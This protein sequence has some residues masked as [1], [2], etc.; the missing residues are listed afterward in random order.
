MSSKREMLE[1]EFEGFSYSYGESIE[2]LAGR[3]AEL[4]SEM[5]KAEMV[6]ST[7]MSNRKLLQAIKGIPDQ[8][9][10]SWFRN[11]NQIIVTTD[12]HCYKMKSDELISLIK[13][14]DN[15]DSSQNSAFMFNKPLAREITKERE[16]IISV[17][18][19]PECRERNEAYRLH[20]AELIQDYNDIK[21][22]NFTLSKN[23][24]LYKDKIEAQRKDIIKLKDDVSVKTA[25]FLEAQEKVCML[26]TELEDIRERYQI[27]ELNI[28]K[29]ESSSKL[30]KNLC[31]QQLAYKKKKGCGLG[32]NQVPPPYNDNY[33]YLPM[34][35]EELMNEDK[36]AYGPKTDKSSINSRPV[37]KRA[38]PPINFVAKGTIDP[39]ASSTCADEVVE[40]TAEKGAWEEQASESNASENLI[41]EANLDSITAF[42]IFKS[43]FRSVINLRPDDLGE[44]V[45]AFVTENESANRANEPAEPSESKCK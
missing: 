19:T 20:N 44:N 41:N 40:V 11:V 39:N 33:T 27:N 25:H 45:D 30:V 4:L 42:D 1:Q 5:K 14:Y 16:E 35:E 7:R 2:A 38:T 36:M 32:F 10:C 22:K 18:C 26:I 23:E 15:A 31:D 21:N 34:T 8:A 29:Y 9:N 12:G 37:D 3:F 43:V 13:S 6:V 17:F 24:K 28:K